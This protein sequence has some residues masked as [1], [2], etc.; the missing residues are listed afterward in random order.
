[1]NFKEIKPGYPVYILDKQGLTVVEGKVTAVGFPYYPVPKEP[2]A[3]GATPHTMQPQGMSIDITIDAGGKTATYTIP[4]HLSVTYAGNI[5]L[6]TDQ[7]GL[8]REVE[9]MKNAAQQVLDSMNRQKEIIAAA[10][11]LLEQLSPVYKE[12][13]ATE[14]RFAALEGAVSEIKGL[15]QGLA[16]EFKN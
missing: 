12:R 3:I 4:E 16:N 8:T 9:A 6:S 11:G 15:I 2:A 13:A 5:V 10:S 1:M 14:K 7:Q